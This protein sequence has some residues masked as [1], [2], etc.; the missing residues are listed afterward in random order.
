[1]DRKKIYQNTLRSGNKE[2]VYLVTRAMLPLREKERIII[3]QDRLRNELRLY[4]Y[5]M[6]KGFPSILSALIPMIIVNGDFESSFEEA[7]H[8]LEK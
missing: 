6:E 1:M 5:N 2:I 3:D 7:L 8:T 4:K